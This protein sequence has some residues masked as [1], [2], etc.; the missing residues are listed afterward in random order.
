MGIEV[1][2]RW[3][4]TLDS[5]TR[6][7]H[8]QLD[9]EAAD[10]EGKF[11]NGCRFP[12]DP[13]GPA[14]EVWNCRCTL[15]SDLDGYDALSAGRMD[16]N[17]EGISY[18]DWKAG[19]NPPESKRGSGRS[20]K[21]FMTEPSVRRR[22]V[23]R[24]MSEAQARKAIGAE[25][26]RQGRDGR[27]FPSLTRSEQQT[28]LSDALSRDKQRRTKRGKY[29]VEQTDVDELV[30]GKLGGVSFTVPPVYNPRVRTAGKTT[31]TVGTDGR[32]TIT[33]EI[34]P[35]DKPGE[36]ELIDTLLHEELEARIF[37]R[38]GKY[39]TDD[40]AFRHEHIN[41]VIARYRKAKGI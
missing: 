40:D 9:G 21:A 20:L 8:R 12:G 2:K 30:V 14:A 18:E 16:K 15:V 4:A 23:K 11:P 5:R 17:L 1:R 29:T 31:K 41:A 13:Q 37:K 10:V 34:G 6:P 7:T 22:L 32:V 25:L 27:S 38:G 24:G 3:V 35:Q 36:S 28:V 33:I 26:A 39:D 19:K